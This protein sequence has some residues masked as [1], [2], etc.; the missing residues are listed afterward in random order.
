MEIQSKFLSGGPGVVFES[1]FLSVNLL[2]LAN[3]ENDIDIQ[4]GFSLETGK[5]IAFYNY[6]FNLVSG[7]NMMPF[8]LFHADRLVV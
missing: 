3:N 7:N 4:T 8:S 2:L 5:M 6:R 1:Q